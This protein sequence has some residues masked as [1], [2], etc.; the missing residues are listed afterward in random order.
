MR[1]STVLL[2]VWLSG[3]AA[4]AETP[5]SAIDWLSDSLAAPPDASA[6]PARQS[7][8][9]PDVTTQP[10]D[11]PRA[12]GAGIV[13]AAV[14]GLPI[15]LWGASRAEDLAQAI[16]AMPRDLPPTA[17]RFFKTLLIAELDPPRG[18]PDGTGLLLARVDRL[19]A[20]GALDEAGTL[21]DMTA[22]RSRELFRRY[23][24]V[25]L[26]T[27]TENA[28]CRDLV[29]DPELFP[30]Y[31]ARAFCIAREGDWHTA[32]VT[33][34]TSNALSLITPEEDELLA[35]FIHPELADGAEPLRAPN[36]PSPLTF[37]LFEA[38]GEALPTG[39]LPLAFAHADLRPTSGWKAQLD[40]AERLTRAGAIDP[41]VLF[42]L[43]TLRSPAASGGIWDRAAAVRDFE[44]ALESGASEEIAAATT[45]VWTALEDAGLAA[46]MASLLAERLRQ[47]GQDAPPEVRRSLYLLAGP[48][49]ARQLPEAATPG[50]D[51]VVDL[52]IGR[53]P[54]GAEDPL[55]TA[56]ARGLAEQGVPQRYRILLSEDRRGEA[57][58]DALSA[59]S[60]SGPR[61]L[62]AVS[63]ALALLSSLG[64]GDMARQAGAELILLGETG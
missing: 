55:A 35:R 64:F 25:A 32:A 54:G 53:D 1:T 61:N 13:P 24:D 31:T 40:A 5:L 22:H 41:T 17:A 63:D 52:A 39:T 57:V 7:A 45:G 16:A 33:L 4:M 29:S 42:G 44:T 18:G 62:S 14:A 27:G 38:I 6:G 49:F 30:T 8:A 60:L 20:I 3:G 9:L 56:V 48:G 15:D 23:F 12:D 2:A 11:A 28:A 37:R 36:R 26:L 50:R 46:P 47:A 59:L 43:Y 58:L 34:E 19:L 51:A 21:I 10:L